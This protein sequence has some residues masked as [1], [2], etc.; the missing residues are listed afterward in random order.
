MEKERNVNKQWM[1]LAAAVLAGLLL[2]YLIFGG[3][4][5]QAGPSG[6][7]SEVGN[8]HIGEEQMW[9]C[10]MHPQ[11]MQ[12]EPGDCPICGM[13]LIPAGTG[14]AYHEERRRQRKG[15]TVEDV[16][17]ATAPAEASAGDTE[18]HVTEG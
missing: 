9:T 2:G 18:E 15:L 8:D 4:D 13:D 12:P 5:Q 10:S 7:A 14:L 17:E 11:I 3:S 6:T 1:Y 16:M